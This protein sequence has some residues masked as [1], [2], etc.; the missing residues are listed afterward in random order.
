[1]AEML[2]KAKGNYSSKNGKTIKQFY[3]HR[4][5]TKTQTTNN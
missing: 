5:Y 1:M 2:D 4:F 3:E